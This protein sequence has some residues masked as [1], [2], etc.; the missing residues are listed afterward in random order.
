MKISV[1]VCN[2][3]EFVLKFSFPGTVASSY[4]PVVEL[5]IKMHYR[6]SVNQYP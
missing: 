1:A 3:P 6:L 4:T 5:I 2:K